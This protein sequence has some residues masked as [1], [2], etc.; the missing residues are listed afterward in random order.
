MEIATIVAV[1]NGIDWDPGSR[2]DMV[3]FFTPTSVQ[4][5]STP[6]SVVALIIISCRKVTPATVFLDFRRATDLDGYRIGQI[7][8]SNSMTE[9]TPEDIDCFNKYGYVVV[10]NAFSRVT[11]ELCREKMWDHIKITNGVDRH[12]QSTW[13]PKVRS[14]KIWHRKDGAPW[15]NVFT[16]K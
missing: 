4:I 2:C 7:I 5:A 6:A 16:E 12:D 15:A 10:K 1:Q 14:D 13:I 8:M 3:K 11:A 9:A